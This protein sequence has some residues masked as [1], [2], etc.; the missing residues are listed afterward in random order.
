MKRI[1]TFCLSLAVFFAIHPNCYSSEIN[2]LSIEYH[3][4]GNLDGTV[5]TDPSDSDLINPQSI[6]RSYDVTSSSPISASVDL[7]DFG[8]EYT[9][10][11]SVAGSYSLYTSADSCQRA[12][13]I[14][15]TGYEFYPASTTA[16]PND[17]F[18][19]MN[20]IFEAPGSFLNFEIEGSGGIYIDS[21]PE[22]SLYDITSDFELFSLEISFDDVLYGELLGEAF[23]QDP[24]PSPYPPTFNLLVPIDSAHEYHLRT[25][26]RAESN[27]DEEGSH[28]SV[29]VT[30]VPEP[31][32][33]FLLGA[34]L[35]GMLSYPKLN[36]KKFRA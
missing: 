30:A 27:D 4:W 29:A 31:S 17:A 14:G 24:Y 5:W 2:V 28:I 26:T 33:M 1:L 12:G 3:V 10:I 35:I 36:R 18:A 16:E 20:L 32:T 34:S 11:S 13:Q 9:H 8:I 7:A 15:T 6:Y 23:Y 22:I 25:Y 19:E 21:I